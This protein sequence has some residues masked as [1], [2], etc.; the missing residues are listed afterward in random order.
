[1]V[2]RSI[3]YILNFKEEKTEQQRISWSNIGYAVF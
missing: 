2:V 1:M 3:A